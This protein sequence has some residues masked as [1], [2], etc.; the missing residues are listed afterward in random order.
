MCKAFYLNGFKIICSI[1]LVCNFE[2]KIQSHLMSTLKLFNKG[3]L[4]YLYLLFI[5]CLDVQPRHLLSLVTVDE[6]LS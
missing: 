3:I 6:T 2:K 1:L 5:L 4:A